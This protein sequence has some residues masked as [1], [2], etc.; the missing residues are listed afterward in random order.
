MRAKVRK[1]ITVCYF[2]KSL[3]NLTLVTQ[4]FF[5]RFIFILTVIHLKEND[6]LIKPKPKRK[7]FWNEIVLCKFQL[8]GLQTGKLLKIENLEMSR[9]EPAN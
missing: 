2:T 9:W 7:Y 3:L 6:N 4:V 8:I 5:H 1:F